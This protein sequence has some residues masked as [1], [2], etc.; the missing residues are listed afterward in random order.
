LSSG[1]PIEPSGVSTSAPP[2]ISASA[3]STSSLLAAQCSGVSAKR[4]PG[5]RVLG[6]APAAISIRA[7]CGPF[8]K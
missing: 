2:S 5:L 6:S 4:V 8:G 3:T 1:V 7:I